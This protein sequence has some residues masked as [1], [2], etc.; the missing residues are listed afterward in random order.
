M[1]STSEIAIRLVLAA[2][3]GAVIGFDRERH[4]WAAGL[5][6]HMLV[7]LGA[8]LTMIVSAFAFSGVLQ[9]WPRVVLDPSRIAAQ[10]ISGIGFLGAGTIMFLHRENVIRGLTTAAGLWTVAAIGLAAGGGMYLAAVITTA[11]AWLILAALK[12]LE[13]RFALRK[14]LPQIKLGFADRAPLAALE[15]LLVGRGLPASSIVARRI[16]DDGDEVTIEF[17]RGFDR[18]KL[19]DL[20]DALRGLPGTQSVSLDVARRGS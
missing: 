13:R 15:A 17:A 8:A 4:T 12:P 16:P 18:L 6:T 1:L 19:G 7:C 14:A 10:V 2:V 11:I 3:L 9:Q 20:A 5:R